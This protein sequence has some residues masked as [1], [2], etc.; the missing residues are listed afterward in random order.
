MNPED[1]MGNREALESALLNLAVESWR[2]SRLF[3]RVLNKMDAAEV[4]RYSNQ[5]RYFQKKVMENLEANGLRAVDLEGQTFDVGMPAAAINMD[6]FGPDD[7]LIVD[8]MVEPIIMGRDGL[9]RQ[10]KVTLRKLSP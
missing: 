2:F 5:L 1:N 3:V 7:T 9:K 8:Q 6:D 10:G 4:G